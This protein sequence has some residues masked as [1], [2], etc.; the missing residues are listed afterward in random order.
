MVMTN[1]NKISQIQYMRK[2]SECPNYFC[3]KQFCPSYLYYQTCARPPATGKTWEGDG[4]KK[5]TPTAVALQWAGLFID[6]SSLHSTQ[7]GHTKG[8]ILS[9]FPLQMQPYQ[10]AVRGRYRC[11]LKIRKYCSCVSSGKLQNWAQS[12]LIPT[13]L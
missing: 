2:C 3:K 7:I 9:N 8:Q 12:Q 6:L 5:K 13:Q 4:I 1:C 11:Y 10:W